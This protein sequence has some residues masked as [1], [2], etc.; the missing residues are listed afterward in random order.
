MP[1]LDF[2]EAVDLIIARD[3]RYDREAYGFLRDALDYTVKLRKKSRESGDTGHVSGQQLLEG[4]RLF[5]LKQFGPMVVT[6][7]GYWGIRS[8]EDF[9]EMVYNLIRTEVFGKTDSDS[10]D[11]FKG[12]YSF[13]EAFVMPFVPARAPAVH[14]R[15]IPVVDAAA[16][17]LN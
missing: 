16:E 17:Q 10:I 9:G 6:V 2:T 13:Q 8:C 15:N 14:R 1:K 12:A 4:V 11:D 5:A 7:F 3:P